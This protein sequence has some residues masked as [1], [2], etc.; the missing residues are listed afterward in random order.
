MSELIN[1][2]NLIKSKN[3]FK[4][5]VLLTVVHA[6]LGEQAFGTCPGEA[7]VMLTI[8]AYQNKDIEKLKALVLAKTKEICLSFDIKYQTEFTEEFPAS[9]ND[10]KCVEI[11]KNAAIETQTEIIELKEA[12]RWSEDFGHFTI[13]NKSAIFGIGSG[14]DHPQLHNEDFDF[15]DEITETVINIFYNIY[16]KFQAYDE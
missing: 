4:D 1:H 15:P 7:V 16:K 10:S 3:A 2:L 6:K 13:N 11:V 8:R 14:I 5:F 12:F 9:I